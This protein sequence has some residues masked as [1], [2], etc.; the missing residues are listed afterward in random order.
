MKHEMLNNINTN[1][2][3][4]LQFQFVLAFSILISLKEMWKCIWTLL[5]WEVCKIYIALTNLNYYHYIWT[6]VLNKVISTWRN[7]LCKNG[8]KKRDFYW[9]VKSDNKSLGNWG[10][11]SWHRKNIEADIP[12]VLILYARHRKH[13]IE[14]KQRSGLLRIFSKRKEGWTWNKFTL[15]SE[16][17]P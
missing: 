11:C 13:K 2:F 8:E 6:T 17:V 9:H 16:L 12:D 5:K 3:T 4:S 7:H 14:S 15:I 1:I 10:I